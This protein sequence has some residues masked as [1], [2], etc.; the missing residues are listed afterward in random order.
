MAM[1][2]TR[3]IQLISGVFSFLFYLSSSLLFTLPSLPTPNSKILNFQRVCVWKCTCKISVTHMFE[4][5]NQVTEWHWLDYRLWFWLTYY[6]LHAPCPIPQPLTLSL[7]LLSLPSSCFLGTKNMETKVLITKDKR[8]QF[9]NEGFVVLLLLYFFSSRLWTLHILNL[10][11]NYMHYTCIQI[12]ERM[13]SQL[14]HPT[15]NNSTYN[16]QCAI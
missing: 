14:T 1:I 16:V 12:H 2:M 3:T 4:N 13:S 10:G 15:W 8:R 11:M 6:I 7:S 9:G 5:E